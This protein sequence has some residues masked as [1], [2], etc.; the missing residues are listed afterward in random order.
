MVDLKDTLVK[1]TS[2]FT[3]QEK[4]KFPSQPQQNPR[5]QYNANASSFGSQ[6]MDQVKLVTTLR[7]GKEGI[8]DEKGTKNV[9]ANHLSKLTIDS[10]SDITPIDDYFPGQSSLSI[11][12]IPWSANIDNFLASGFLPA[13]LDTQDKRKFLSDVKNFYWDDPYLFKYCLD[14][15]FQKSIPDNEVSSIIKFC[16]FEAYGDHFS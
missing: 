13:H 1:F 11:A 8:E 3:F 4:D 7:S 5:G 16:H 12:S 6:H 14:Q 10:T 9:V 15:I 2:A